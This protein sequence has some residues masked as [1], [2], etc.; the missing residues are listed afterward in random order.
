[1]N[2]IIE[3]LNNAGEIFCGFA[4]GMLW[5]SCV[6]I[7]I[8]YL[9]DVL[10]RKHTRAVFRYCIWMLVFVKL[11]L[12]PTLCLPT[13]L[14]YWC[15]FDIASDVAT[16]QPITQPE[17]VTPQIEDQLPPAVLE[18]ENTQKR[19]SNT[20][21]NDFSQ[22]ETAASKTQM[23]KNI[24]EPL[25][26]EPLPAAVAITWQAVVF[27]LWL[28]G[29]LVLT[30]LL[31]QRF[32]FVKSLIAQS[33][34]A[35]GDLNELLNSCRSKIGVKRAIELRLTKNMLSPA[36]CGLL[37]PVILMPA[38][39]LDKLSKEKLEAVLLHEL[40]HI[41]RG[42]LWLNFLQTLLQ[43]V[44]FYNPLLWFANAIVRGLREK[45]VDEMVLAKLGERAGNYSSTL[46]D[47]AEIAFAK[48]HF[49]L[50]LVG[51]VESKKALKDRIKHILSRPLPKSAKLGFAGML[52][53]FITA[54]ILL[55]M[56]KAKEVGENEFSVS[57]KNG[58]TVELVAVCDYPSAGKQ[59]WAPTGKPIGYAIE[60]DDRS[61]YVFDDPG[62]EFIFRKNGNADFKIQKIK[63]S[64]TIS[65]LA[66]K[67]PEALIGKRGHIKSRY[68]KTDI[69]IASPSG[70][71]KTIVRSTGGGS[72][73]GTMN[74]KTIVL[75][76]A[77]RAGDDVIIS[78]SNI[79]NYKNA[80]RIVAVN[81]NG[82]IVTGKIKTDTSVDG[83]RQR[84]VSFSNIKLDDIAE[85]MF[86]ACG[87][88]YHIFKKVS[89]ELSDSGR[90]K[91]SDF[92]KTL[93]NGVSVEVLGVCKHPSEGKQWWRPEGSAYY[94]NFSTK[95]RGRVS[96]SG[97]PYEIAIKVNGSGDFNIEW[98]AKGATGSCELEV[99]GIGQES[100]DGI[101]AQ[102]FNINSDDKTSIM[103]GIA[104]GKWNTE[105]TNPG[106]GNSGMG[107][108]GHGIN[109]SKTYEV[110]DGIEVTVSDDFIDMDYRLI[111][112]DK[113]DKI[114][115]SQRHGG[116]TAGKVR[117]ITYW[118][119]GLDVANVKEF[120]FQ[121]RPF[122]LVEF[123]NIPLKL[124]EPLGT[125][126]LTDFNKTLS[127]GVAIEM[128]GVC[129][130]PDTDRLWWTPDGELIEEQPYESIEN[131]IE[132]TDGDY[133]LVQFALNILHSNIEDIN[134][135]VIVPSAV[136]TSLRSVDSDDMQSDVLVKSVVC[137]VPRLF[138]KLNQF[139]IGV[140]SGKWIKVSTVNTTLS[141]I[142]SN[143]EESGKVFWDDFT[144]KDGRASV[145][146]AHT[147]SDQDFIVF[148][149]DIKGNMIKAY[150]SSTDRNTGKYQFSL[151]KSEI[152]ALHFMRRPY[153]FLEFGNISLKPKCLS[154]AASSNA[155]KNTKALRHEEKASKDNPLQAENFVAALPNGVSVEVL[156]LCDPLSEGDKQWWKPDGGLLNNPV[157][158]HGIPFFSPDKG[159]I[160]REVVLKFF[161]IN[162]RGTGFELDLST[163]L[164]G[165]TTFPLKSDV[166]N[167]RSIVFQAP[168]EA[169]KT[170]IKIGITAGEWKDD[171]YPVTYEAMTLSS[172]LA[173]GITW[174]DAYSDGEN[175][176][177]NLTF[178]STKVDI[179]VL[180]VDHSGKRHPSVDRKGM[181]MKEFASYLF[182]FDVP[183]GKVKS[184][185]LQVRDY[186][187][188]EFK[189]I[190][191]NP[192]VEKQSAENEILAPSDE[193]LIREYTVDRRVK[194]FD[195]KDD[196]STPESAYVAG[197]RIYASGEHY[198]WKEVS[199]ESLAERHQDITEAD[200]AD[201]P[202]D[203]KNWLL[204]TLVAKVMIC[205][206]NAAVIGKRPLM[207]QGNIVEKIFDYREYLFENG[208]WLYTS[209]GSRYSSIEEAEGKFAQ[210]VRYSIVESDTT[211]TENNKTDLI[212]YWPFDGDANDKIGNNHG[213]VYG[214]ILTEGVLG[215]AYYFEGD[216]DCIDIPRSSIYDFGMGDL[217]ISAWF[218]TST[219]KLPFPFIVNFRQNDNNPHIEL[220]AS[221]DLG[222]HLLPGFT[223][224]TY[225]EA[226][227]D[228][229]KWHHMAVTLDNGAENGYKLYLDGEKVAE[230]TY[231]GRLEDWDS[232]TI[233]AQKK[234][235]NEEAA[236]KGFID[237]VA[238][239]SKPLTSKEIKA[240]YISMNTTDS[241]SEKIVKDVVKAG[242]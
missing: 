126:K 4:W 235:G 219:N 185:V 62:Y 25:P 154:S 29:V 175:T 93:S 103:V 91:L 220:Y 226:G 106:S 80:T 84:T 47:V 39:L 156:G 7:L 129:D 50:R 240:L 65:G 101:Y 141:E 140:A 100:V 152:K 241:V 202:L 134:V 183:L 13:G 193:N 191:L 137:S 64:D 81:S 79:E 33:D 89:L 38:A 16:S 212:S 83:L 161:G 149:E 155:A 209:N 116:T 43:I 32:L 60:T 102:R 145:K 138:S 136:R 184:F 231:T 197:V 147:L 165:A 115:V 35:C 26:Q 233:G 171:A 182:T 133:K 69:K 121:T 52:A 232:I 131:I 163:G 216:G 86:Q 196:L 6:L 51:V 199:I 218:R 170:D 21:S 176:K 194:D 236:F 45:A 210:L 11:M 92:K 58:T 125:K 75:A 107:S 189:N 177:L 56:A 110:D 70:Q 2:A 67:E 74:G 128:I 222:S 221:Y 90:A 228:D 61:N 180:A 157:P 223:R 108:F 229:D 198:R 78:C 87:Y 118:F 179:R 151:P 188:M 66:V 20:V 40:A 174:Q 97:K 37:N 68:K 9:I 104:K 127:N 166:L 72:V 217:T 34:K 168:P 12:S 73:S 201:I 59:W 164:G 55:P 172:S 15:Q 130:Y 124:D 8:L 114:Y 24:S 46:I 36:A 214:A 105:F 77:E 17:T 98:G 5:Q 132:N 82:S 113:A 27:V 144:E 10:I 119:K 96:T 208:K 111:A 204:D 158:E 94:P 173:V 28:V 57:F 3:L 19:A 53:V 135:Q 14:G 85:F 18:R 167:G 187:W 169:D 207:L 205:G 54:A 117:Q 190:A 71:W 178:G 95:Q 112:V 227:I 1:M 242:Y 215:Q 203:L 42:D 120:R 148:A 211:F 23:P 186:Q 192:D 142:F 181:P 195:P 150:G 22:L 160:G 139:K 206:N 88:E 200:N 230:A 238:V 30:V 213:T 162:A 239:Y 224:L 76:A 109:F 49:S 146:L 44:Y 234:G 63:G 225:P 237:E 143:K 159:N 41:K 99:S 122:E 123:E 153:Q 31:C 48:P